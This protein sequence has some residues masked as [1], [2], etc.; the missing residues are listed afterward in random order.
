MGP[1]ASLKPQ[2]QGTSGFGGAASFSV[3]ASGE[4]MRVKGMPRSWAL[5]LLTSYCTSMG[6]LQLHLLCLT[7]L[8]ICGLVSSACGERVPEDL[9]FSS[10]LSSS[11]PRTMLSQ[12]AFFQSCLVEGTHPT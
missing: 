4:A 1:N 6:P 9:E 7:V 2:I 12:L 8:Q 11:S 5:G 3:K 10:G